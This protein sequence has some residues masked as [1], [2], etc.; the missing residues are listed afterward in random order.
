MSN[1]TSGLFVEERQENIREYV[2][3]FK[4]VSVSELIQHCKVS[5]S[6]IRNDLAALEKKGLIHRTHVGK[7]GKGWCRIFHLKPSF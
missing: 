7:P 3:R 6:T 2:E 4:R 5:P 1:S